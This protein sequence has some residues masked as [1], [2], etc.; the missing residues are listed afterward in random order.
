MGL[1]LTAGG[2]CLCIVDST[3]MYIADADVLLR[4]RTGAGVDLYADRV[5]YPD[6]VSLWLTGLRA[7]LPDL[8]QHQSAARGCRDLINFLEAAIASDELI[9]IH[10]D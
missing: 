3:L 9:E 10:G 5:L 4:Q 8:A 7:A 2:R 1:D 6:H